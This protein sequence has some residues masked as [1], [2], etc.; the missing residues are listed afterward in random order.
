MSTG[1]YLSHSRPS[2][3]FAF[4]CFAKE[5]GSHCRRYLWSMWTSGY[6]HFL[7]LTR[8]C[9]IPLDAL[10]VDGT[11]TPRAITPNLD[12][13][14]SKTLRVRGVEVVKGDLQD[15]E[16][17]VR[18]LQGSEVVF[19]VRVYISSFQFSQSKK[20]PLHTGH[21]LLGSY[22]LS[23]ESK[24]RDGPRK[25]SRRCVEGAGVKVF[26]WSC[27]KYSLSPPDVHFYL[28]R[29]RV[30]GYHLAPIPMQRRYLKG[31]IS[32]HILTVRF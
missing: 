15:K 6:V 1:V 4:Q 21:E 20:S 19:G 12:S 32:F 17:L 5:N 14:A 30:D 16:S 18:A 25:E 7:V 11:F 9:Y 24:R 10:L 26:V 31:N 27:V 22:D 29:G 28:I 3:L 23:C 13:E 2:S 8:E